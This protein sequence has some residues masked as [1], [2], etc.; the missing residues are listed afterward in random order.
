VVLASPDQLTRWAELDT[1]PPIL[2]KGPHE[3]WVAALRLR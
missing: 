2:I 1:E 3:P